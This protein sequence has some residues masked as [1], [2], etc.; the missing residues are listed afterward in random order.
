MLLV[1]EMSRPSLA[2]PP[3]GLR[4]A[5]WLLALHAILGALAIVAS[6][7]RAVLLWERREPARPATVERRRTLPPPPP[8]IERRRA[9]RAA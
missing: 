5:T 6:A 3:R 7:L 9:P 2:V 4:R 8:T 1:A